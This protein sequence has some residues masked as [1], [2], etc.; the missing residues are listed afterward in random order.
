MTAPKKLLVFGAV[1]A[2]AAFAWLSLPPPPGPASG[3]HGGH[4]GD[5]SAFSSGTVLAVDN[6]ANTITISHGPLQNLGMP[7]MTMVFQVSDPA[8][9]VE[10]KPG[11]KVRFHADTV[12][13]AFRVTRIE[14]A[15]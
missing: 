9:L 13:G 14:P 5:P 3:E 15:Q 11:D 6:T 7:P 2:S 4:G 1:A 12:G 10:V 8:V